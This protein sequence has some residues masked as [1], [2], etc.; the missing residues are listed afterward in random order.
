LSIA[1]HGTDAVP[2]N[3]GDLPD[4]SL[5]AHYHLWNQIMRPNNP[6]SP[7]EVIFLLQGIAGL[8][9]PFLGWVTFYRDIVQRDAQNGTNIADRIFL[10]PVVE[11]HVINGGH[12]SVAPGRYL[13][14]WLKW[15]NKEVRK[16]RL[17]DLYNRFMDQQQLPPFVPTMTPYDMDLD[18]LLLAME[19]EGFWRDGHLGAQTNPT[20]G[21]VAARN[22][23]RNA[24][25]RWP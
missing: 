10:M 22:N 18:D 11:S 20:D 4:P 17:R 7:V 6:N 16:V 13:P 24:A 12:T 23:G 14:N 19:H 2:T 3:I 9:T 15:G 8:S 25:W 21:D 1:R 5:T